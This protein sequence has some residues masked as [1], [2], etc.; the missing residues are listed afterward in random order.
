MPLLTRD[1]IMSAQDV[2][3]EIVD[4][5]EWGEGAQVRV[6]GLT[7]R[8]RDRYEASMIS[9]AGKRMKMDLNNIRA[10]LVA[11]TVVDEGGNPLF[12]DADI[13]ALGNKSAA[14]LQRIYEAAQRLSG[15]SDED[16]EELEKN[17]GSLSSDGFVSV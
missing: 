15:L 11:W 10:R 8:Q 4:V 17:S 3:T 5:P 13:E 12:N 2:Q 1:A 9:G 6:R 7:G 14:A 16:M